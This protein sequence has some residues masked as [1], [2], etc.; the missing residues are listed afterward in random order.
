M[1]DPNPYAP[2]QANVDLKSPEGGVWHEGR[3]VVV[4][5]RGS[6]LPPRCVRCNAPA[7]EPVRKRRYYWHHPA[8]YLLLI[9]FPFLNILVLLLYALV[10]LVVRKRIEV[11]PGQCAMHRRRRLIRL[12][13]AWSLFAAGLS[14]IGW[15]VSSMDRAP[16]GVGIVFLLVAIVMAAIRPRIVYP[17]GIFDDRAR[18]KGFGPAFL[19]SLPERA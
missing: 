1:T 14:L 2:P 11:S 12:G 10:A 6:D 13:A 18:L 5:D 17:I 4:V 15:S 8:W 7:V 9:A 3:S 19:A 16:S